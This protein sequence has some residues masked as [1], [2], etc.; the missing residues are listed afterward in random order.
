[1][2]EPTISAGWVG[3]SR[4]V[5][6]GTADTGGVIPLAAALRLPAELNQCWSTSIKTVSCENGVPVFVET[7]EPGLFWSFKHVFHLFSLHKGASN[8]GQRSKAG[9]TLGNEPRQ[10]CASLPLLWDQHGIRRLG[11]TLVKSPGITY[12]YLFLPQRKP[13]ACSNCIINIIAV[14]GPII[15][16]FEFRLLQPWIGLC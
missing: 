15:L 16:S 13:K 12:H 9:C 7:G 2:C 14:G 6:P 11:L 5:K 3:W 1:M 4:P 10:V 8:Q